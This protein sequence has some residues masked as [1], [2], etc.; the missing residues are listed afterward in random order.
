MPSFSVRAASAFLLIFPLLLAGCGQETPQAPPPASRPVKLFTVGGGSSDAIR[1]FPGRVDATQRAELGFR[2]GG[3]LQEV[4]VKEGDL[5]EKGQ[6]LARLDPTDYEIVLED[7][8]AN[9]DNA[10]RNFERG[11]ELIVDGNISRID[12]DRM[13]ADFRTASAALSAAEQDVEYTVLS[14]PFTGR[15][16]ARSVENFEEVLARQTVIWLQNID[17]LDVIINLP[18]SVVRSVRSE[19]GPHTDLRR[20]ATA[21]GIRAH[22]QFDGRGGRDYPL[23]PKEIATKADDQTQTFRVTFTMDAPKEFN[24]L[25]GMTATVVLDLSGVVDRDAVKWV[26]ARAVQGDSGLEPRVWVLDAETMTVSARPVEIGR[27]SGRS[28]EIVSGLEGGEEVVAVGAPYLAEG[29][30]VTRLSLSEQAVPRADDP[31]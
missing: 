15:I 10:R 5:V 28:I 4:L 8:R 30:K 13:E 12:F 16:A 9:Y 22:A 18:E 2:V 7:R 24:V 25:P 27:M 26:P 14:A 31:L 29:M 17:E 1:T 20:S 21:G 3:Q 19:A 23:R 6:V 11:K